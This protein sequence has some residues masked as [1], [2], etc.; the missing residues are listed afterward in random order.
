MLTVTIV[1]VITPSCCFCVLAVTIA[2]VIT[3]S[4]VVFHV[5]TVTIVQVIT[6]PSLGHEQD[7]DHRRV[8]DTDIWPGDLCAK[9]HSQSI[10]CKDGPQES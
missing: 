9:R 5:L 2:Q 7:S 1:Q 8:F 10:P 4:S 6:P 3:P